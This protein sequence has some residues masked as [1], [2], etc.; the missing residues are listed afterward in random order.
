MKGGD[1][2]LKRYIVNGLEFQYEEGTQPKG[3]VEVKPEK[4]AA[5]PLNKAVKPANKARKAAK[6]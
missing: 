6:K 3:A 2:M 4:K 1:P 5:E